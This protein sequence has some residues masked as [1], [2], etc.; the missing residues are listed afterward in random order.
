MAKAGT[1]AK[2]ARPTGRTD[3]VSVSLGGRLRTL[4]C[5]FNALALI[6]EHTGLNLV[7]HPE[8]L[9]KLSASKVRILAWAFLV[10]EDPDL[11]IAQ[12]GR[13]IAVGN[14]ND[15][16]RAL[17]AALNRSAEGGDPKAAAATGG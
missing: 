2:P 11:T 7:E 14:S 12:V 8:A 3:A 1:K 15:V 16:V 5:D 6:E 10:D 13:M 9:L 17:V 4:R